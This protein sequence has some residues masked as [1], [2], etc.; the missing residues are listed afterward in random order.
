[1][2]LLWCYLFLVVV[3]QSILIS[4]FHPAEGNVDLCG[5]P[6]LGPSQSHLR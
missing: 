5:P 3:F 1:M 2:T 6:D 4:L